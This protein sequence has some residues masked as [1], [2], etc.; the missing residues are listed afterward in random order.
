MEFSDKPSPK[1]L[2]VA[3][4]SARFDS[5]RVHYSADLHDGRW[6]PPAELPSLVVAALEASAATL[7][8]LTTCRW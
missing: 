3:L 2:R 7:T 8:A 4:S 1:Q 6:P 5:V